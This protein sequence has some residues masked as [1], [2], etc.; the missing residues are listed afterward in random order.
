M[1]LWTLPYLEECWYRINTGQN[2][3]YIPVREVWNDPD[4]QDI[5]ASSSILSLVLSPPLGSG[6]PAVH[7]ASSS[8]TFPEFF[9]Q[10]RVPVAARYEAE[11]RRALEYQLVWSSWKFS[12]VISF[13]KLC[14]SEGR[15]IFVQSKKNF[16]QI[17]H[18]QSQEE[19]MVQNDVNMVSAVA[20]TFFI[21]SLLLWA[22]FN[23]YP[24]HI[25]VRW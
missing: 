7:V 18:K 24:F 4:T 21:L 2:K 12:K 25:V 8:P 9:S 23:L 15:N 22:W 10:W 5:P 13:G 20:V 3:F 19:L 1:A 14:I 11:N 17:I 16:I 6:G